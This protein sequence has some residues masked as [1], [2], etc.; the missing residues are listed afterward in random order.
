MI[1]VFAIGCISTKAVMLKPG[2]EKFDPVPW[3]EVRV[4][5][6]EED[7]P[8]EFI[9][10]AIVSSKEEEVLTTKGLT[11]LSVEKQMVKKMKERAGK[12]GANAIILQGVLGSKEIS[13][14]AIRVKEEEKEE[15]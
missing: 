6:S 4:Y 3:E 10:I 1:A 9:E 5:L 2:V 15:T 14:I 13:A 8:G 11:A 12:L 7:A